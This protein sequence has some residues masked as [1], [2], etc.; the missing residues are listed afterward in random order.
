MIYKIIC[1]TNPNA[2]DEEKKRKESTGFAIA[3][4]CTQD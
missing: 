1:N 2:T 4:T 3:N